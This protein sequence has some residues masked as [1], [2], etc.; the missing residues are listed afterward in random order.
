MKNYYLWFREGSKINQI[1]CALLI[2]MPVFVY[3]ASIGW[4]S[5]MTLLLQSDKSPKV[6]PLTDYEVS[7]MAAV[8]Y[9]V[10]FPANFLMA[11]LGDRIGRKNTIFILSGAGFTCWAIKLLSL[12]F[13]AFVSARALVGVL[14]AGS[15]VTCPLYTKEISEDSVRGML[16]S[17]IIVF[18][19]TGNLFVYVIGD[20]LSYRTILWICLTIPAVHMVLFMMMPESPSFLVKTGDME[21]AARCLAWL[22]CRKEDDIVIQDELIRIKNEQIKD[23]E[24]NKYVFRA[25]FT[26]KLIFRA[27]KIAL[28]MSLAREFCGAIPVLNFAG[29]IFSD[30]S[31]GT[32]LVFSP[33]Q[34]AMV[35]GAVQVI[36]SILGFSLVERAG[37]KP[38]FIVTALIS[39]LSMCA[40]ASWFILRD[41]EVCD[42][43]QVAWLPIAALC[44]CIFCD[45]SGLQPVSVIIFGEMFSYKYRGTAIAASNSSGSLSAFFQMLVY[46]P[47]VNA[48]GFYVTFYCFGAVCLLTA[49][50]VILVMPETKQRGLEEIYEDLKTKK[51]KKLEADQTNVED[52]I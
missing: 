35:L 15:Y 29:A 8:A 27:F 24:S 47:I 25:I 23:Q 10:S 43:Y 4:M 9:M 5:P 36:G 37:R 41:F 52:K 6:P 22:R 14:M 34:Q 30:A 17:L 46:K 33:N 45:S 11:A 42:V 16:G 50:Y 49:V 44:L 18:H 40:L 3:G 51:E 1:I 38:L 12:E 2:N 39:G 7:C 32:G 20:F 13:A 31:K 28:V 21:E 48:I 26:D 19:T